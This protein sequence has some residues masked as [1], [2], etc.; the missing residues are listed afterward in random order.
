MTVRIREGMLAVPDG[1][2]WYRSVGEGG[3]PLLCLHGD[4]GMTHN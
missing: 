4:P 3:A 1:R 2:V